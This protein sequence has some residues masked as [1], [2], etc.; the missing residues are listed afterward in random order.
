MN[1]TDLTNLANL[2]V[3]DDPL[4]NGLKWIGVAVALVLAAAAPIMAY[5]RKFKED[6]AANSKDDAAITLY[7]QLQEQ[8]RQNAED[9]R[10]LS[11][12]RDKW[13]RQATELQLDYGRLQQ[14]MLALEEAEATIKTL[15]ERLEE[16]EG[17]ISAR[18]AENRQLIIEIMGLKDRI[19][20]LEIRL[21]Q[22]EEKFCDG[23]VN[24][25]R[26]PA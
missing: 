14:R 11:E 24:R 5:I 23:C 16:K 4:I 2:P 13:Q 19:H 7:N 3:S 18:D 22:D 6:A 25:P 10:K 21:T 8:I 26:M 1:P 9:I 20:S 15:R 17:I 12:D